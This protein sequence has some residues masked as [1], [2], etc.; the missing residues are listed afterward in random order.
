VSF[1]TNGGVVSAQG[2]TDEL[3]NAF[4]EIKT[5]P[6]IPRAGPVPDPGP[7]DPRTGFVTVIAVTQGEET[8]IDSN[9][10]GLFDGPGEFDPTDPEID[11][12]EPFV[13]HVNLC[14]GQPFPALCPADPLIPPFLSGDGVF[15]PDNRFELF[16]DGNG[17]AN[18]DLPNGVWDA[19]KAIFATTTVLF[20]GVTQLFVG[21]LQP[22]DSCSGNPSG[23]DVPDGGS[24]QA[25]CFIVSDP[26]GRPLVGGTEISVTTSAGAISGTANVTLPDTQRGGPGITFFTFAVVDDDPDDDDPPSEALVT[27]SVISPSS[28]T[29]PGGNGDAAISFAGRVD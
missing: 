16:F 5:G 8:F 17:N 15:D 27:V 20:S 28:A 14:N 6:P 10:N 21:E 11:T 19:N 29:C 12:T 23:F 7:S 4:S 2:L 18:W 1:F 3:G 22:D 24:S 26:A 9:A 25:F 13:D